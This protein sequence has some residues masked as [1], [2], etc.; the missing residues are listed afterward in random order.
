V[1]L[2]GG[3][4]AA[5]ECWRP[6]NFG[7]VLAGELFAPLMECEQEHL[8]GEGLNDIQ[9]LGKQGGTGRGPGRT[10]LVAGLRQPRAGLPPGCTLLLLGGCWRQRCG[11]E[12][13]RHGEEDVRKEAIPNRSIALQKVCCYDTAYNDPLIVHFLLRRIF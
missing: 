3:Q 8:G 7:W 10:V 2:G 4:P 11:D 5:G 12:G 13:K 1:Q 9:N 6:A